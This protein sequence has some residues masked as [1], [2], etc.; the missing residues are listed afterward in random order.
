[1]LTGVSVD[2]YVRLER[3]NLAG[4]SQSVLDALARTLRLDEAER[5]YLFD[6]ARA[7]APVRTARPIPA[8]S[9]RPAVLQILE[10]VSDAPAWVRNARH[11]ILASNPMGRALYSP[12]FDDPR[13]P[14]NTTRFTYL[15]PAARQFWRDYDKIA[16]DAAAMLRLEAGR[17]PHDPGLITLIGELSTQSE[18]F[19]Q[20]WASRD[21]MHHRS[22]VKRIH[23][24]V[25]GD[26]DLNFESLE[27][28]S[29]PGLVMNV[30]TAPAGSPTADALKVLA[31]WA[32]TQQTAGAAA[33]GA[34]VE[35]EAQAH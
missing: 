32:A 20:R 15:N 21:V 7:A 26:L 19:R 6:L 1:M 29:E 3:G 22:G 35:R 27:L 34:E 17:N 23:H 28:P 18:V 24:P 12:V 30:Y 9:V 11:D 16:N 2:Y 5:E 10:A 8:P 14:V 13:R 25:V 33:A 31:S 4:A